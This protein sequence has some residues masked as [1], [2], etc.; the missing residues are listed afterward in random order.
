MRLNFRFLS[1][2]F[3]IGL[4][5]CQP[6]TLDIYV[7]PQGN[8]DQNGSAEKPIKTLQKAKDLASSY[9]GKQKVNIILEDGTYYLDETLVFDFKDSGTEEF[10]INFRAAHEGEAV[11]SGG[12]ELN[13]SWQSYQNGIYQAKVN[14]DINIDQLYINGQRQRMARFPN[15]VE[16]KNVFDTWELVH[17][18]EPDPKNDPLNPERIASWSN[19][20]GAYVHAMHSALWGDMHWL[21]NGK[22]EDGSLDL[23]GGWQN[24]RPSPM[25]PR[26]RMVENV[27]EELDVPG[28]WF[29]NQAEGMLYYYPSKEMNLASAKVEIVRLK[30]LIEFRGTKEKPVRFINLQ[31]LVFK[32]AARSFMEN[33]EQLLRSDWTVYRGGAIVYYGAE[34]CSVTDCEFDQLG[35]NSIF[36]NNYNRRLSFK[37]C[38]IHHGGANGIAFVGDPAMVRSPLFRYGKQDFEKIDR[39]PGPKGDN[40]PE[41]CLVEDCL[42]TMTGRD[43]KQTSPVQIS[44]A[45]KITVRHCSIY[46]V[47]RAGINISE[48]TFGGHVIEYCD[49]FNTVLETGDH[50]SFNSWGR[51]RFW[52]PD[53]R[54]TDAEMKK[55]PNLFKL[56]MLAPNTI[57]N[58]RWRCDHGWDIDLDDGSSWYTIYNNLLLNGGLKMR[59]GYHRTATN[60]IIINNSLHPHVWYPESGDVFMHNIVFGAYRPAVMQR[61]IAADGKWGQ[62]LDYNL[63][64]TNQEDREKFQVN[65][66]DQNSMVGDPMFINPKEG[67]FAVKEDSPALKIGFK[68]FDMTQFGVVSEKLRK[69]AKTPN[70]PQKI[71]SGNTVTGKVYTWLGAK[72]K[73]VETLGEQSANGLSSMSGVLLLDV[74][75]NSELGQRGFNT[76]DVIVGVNK[77]EVKTFEQLLQLFQGLQSKKNCT[78]NMMRN[79]QAKDLTVSF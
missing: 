8:D 43:E 49:V 76:S 26:Y 62:E 50:G 34:D 4:V 63:F 30:H 23:E 11:V 70:I 52:T 3:L 6:K 55:D 1:F 78:I 73:N 58:S 13:L 37:S 20:E 46:D 15:A 67:N 12:K 77:Q 60:N 65:G 16:G 44:M 40:Y 69:I 51:D 28:E 17:T 45:H 5:A 32:H 2:L 35:G 9:A 72:V 75:A 25:H 47:P 66:C 14:G 79:Q 21:V 41:D 38:Y 22:N 19:P 7:S 27:F 57:R 68:N 39:T 31:G 61:A 36:V 48:G 18:K 24:N 29:F 54:E 71:V 42:I 64:A 59:E 74:P 33:K 10:P 56:D 53:I